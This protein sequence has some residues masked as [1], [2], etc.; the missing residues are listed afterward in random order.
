MQY[1]YNDF[2]PSQSYYAFAHAAGCFDDCAFGDTTQPILGC[3]VEK[4]TVTLQNASNYI[5]ASGSMALA[6]SYP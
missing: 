1:N 3:L 5:S 2:V 6:A 4:E